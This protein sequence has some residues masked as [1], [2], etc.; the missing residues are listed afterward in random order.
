TLQFF[1]LNGY[2]RFRAYLFHA[3]NLG[4]W[5]GPTSPAAPFFIPYSEFGST[6]QV[7]NNTGPTPNPASSCAQRDHSNCR[8]DNLTSADMRLRLQPT[9]NVTEQVRVKAMLDIFDNLVLG[10]TPQGYFINRG[11]QLHGAAPTT[12]VPLNAFSGS[13]VAPEPGVNSVYS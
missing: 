8:T 9:V 10:S 5:P 6:G 7:A 13:Q 1:Q 4:I 11:N 2:I 12:D 3:L